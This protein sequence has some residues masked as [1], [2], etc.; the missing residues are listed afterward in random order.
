MLEST[1]ICV[2]VHSEAKSIMKSGN[3]NLFSKEVAGTL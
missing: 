2:T 3:T 1:T